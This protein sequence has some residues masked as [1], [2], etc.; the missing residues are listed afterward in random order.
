MAFV[1]N[2]LGS[3]LLDIVELAPVDLVMIEGRRRLIGQGVPLG[4]VSVLLEKAECDAAV[5][6]AREAEPIEL[7]SGKSVLVPF[8][9]AEHDWAALE[10]GSWL[11][12]STGADLRLLGAA[13]QSDE[14][15]SLAR[16][17]DDAQL[18]VQQATGVTSEPLV[19]AGGRKAI[20]EAA[21]DASLLVIGLSDRWRREGLGPTRSEIAKAAP[22][23]V[24]F[25]R[26]GTRPG[27]F[28]PRESVTQFKWSMAGTPSEIAGDLE[29]LRGGSVLTDKPSES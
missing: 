22:A 17:L 28:A 19:V 29:A 7:G 8:G 2:N 16:M 23:P 3:D 20:V 24:L 18:L 13:G 15:K 11:S 4:E 12:S 10:L 25:V 6:I 1:S 21:A 14:R 27:L 26:R 5:L 9:G